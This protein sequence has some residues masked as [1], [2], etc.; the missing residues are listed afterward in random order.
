MSFMSLKAGLLAKIRLFARSESG[1]TL[2][3]M[4]LSMIVMTGFAGLA[5]D[6]GRMQMVQSKLQFSLDAAGLAAGST[7]S[8]TSLNAEAVKYLK[9]DF[10]CGTGANATCYMGASLSTNSPSVTANSTNTVFTLS[11]TA[12]VPT[13][14]MGV[15]GVS[16]MTVTANSQISRAVTGLELVFVLDNTGSMT[17][18]AGGTISK[19]QALKNASTTLVNT[20]FGGA[21]TSTNGKLWVGIVPFSQTV[22]IGTSHTSWIDPDYVYDGTTDTTATLDWG[23]NGS[24]W[25]GCVDARLSGEDITDDPPSSGTASTL[26]GKYYWTS[27]NL[28]TDGIN[29]SNNNEWKF[30]AYNQCVTTYNRCKNGTCVHVSPTCSTSGSHTCTLIAPTCTVV[31]SCTTNSTT[32]C[33]SAGYAYA[34][35][36]NT[37]DQGPN[38]NCPQQITTMTNTSTT[39][40]TAITAMTAQ[41]N[42][43]VNQ[44]LEWGWHLLSP[45]WQG[46]WGG[47][48]STNGLPLAYNTQGMAKAVVLLTD[49]DNTIDNG[50][51]GSYWFLGSG[52]TGSTSSSSAV[53]RLDN[54]T[55]AL[56]TAMKAQGIYIYTIGL[57]AS[58]INTT[59]LRNC[60]TSANYAFISPSTSDL[61]SI[62][63]TIGDSLSNLRVSQ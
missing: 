47:T 4:G 2:P 5:I 57:G 38:L 35:P 12:T 19:I 10:G 63:D 52:R 61:Q 31:Q 26:F 18:S 1:M 44:G 60:A 29:N 7:V 3:L 27:D 25:G 53:T 13:T 49:G 55:L 23:N 54:K 28:N 62:F 8:T 11:A 58:G 34:S 51:H 22:N 48:M 42:T 9:A 30:P 45:R 16:S 39:L 15:V 14:F 59:L 50:S 40:L 43:E 41:G 6:V 32:T 17:Q 56:C 33:S 21:T 24:D 37:V 20:L 36:L 46:L